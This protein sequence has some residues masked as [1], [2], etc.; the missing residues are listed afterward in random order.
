[1][2]EPWRETKGEKDWGARNKEEYINTYNKSHPVASS[3]TGEYD[4]WAGRLVA[5]LRVYGC[6]DGAA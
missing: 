2:P 5:D 3:V 4:V 1:M 6:G